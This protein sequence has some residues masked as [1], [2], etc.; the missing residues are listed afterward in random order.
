MPWDYRLHLRLL[1]EV[2]ELRMLEGEVMPSKPLGLKQSRTY[3][4]YIL[5]C[6]QMTHTETLRVESLQEL[7]QL[8]KNYVEARGPLHIL[9]LVDRRT[10]IKGV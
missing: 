3:Y 8:V 1:V 5:Q 2:S 9:Y 10:D 4:Y 7:V 6:E